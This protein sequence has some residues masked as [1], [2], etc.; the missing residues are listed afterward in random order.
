MP[1][2]ASYAALIKRT[3]KQEQPFVDGCQLLAE[4]DPEACVRMLS[5][6]RG[7]GQVTKIDC[8]HSKYLQKC[9][10]VILVCMEELS[11]GKYGHAFCSIRARFQCTQNGIRHFSMSLFVIF[12]D[13]NGLRSYFFLKN[14]TLGNLKTFLLQKSEVTKLPSSKLYLFFLYLL[15]LLFQ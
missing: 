2:G 7:V 9:V 10:I 5:A 8:A 12:T 6:L 4:A 11:S 14:K 15:M 1:F 3:S 13:C